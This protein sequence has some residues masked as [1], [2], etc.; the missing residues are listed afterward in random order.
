MHREGDVASAFPHSQVHLLQ[1]P[2]PPASALWTD[3]GHQ[4]GAVHQG[5]H[6]GAVDQGRDPGKAKPELLDLD[7]LDGSL[8]SLS[9]RVEEG[10]REKRERKEREKRE[11]RERK[12]RREKKDAVC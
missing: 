6:C 12:E 3:E 2:S 7:L 9:G 5:E 10:G 11:K 1:P 8:W 4:R